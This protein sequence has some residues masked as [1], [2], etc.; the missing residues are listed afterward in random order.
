MRGQRNARSIVVGTG[1]AERTSLKNNVSETGTV[2]LVTVVGGWL[3]VLYC[4]SHRIRIQGM[5]RSL[6]GIPRQSMWDAEH[7][8]DADPNCTDEARIYE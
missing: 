8:V 5:L 2:L 3:A 6:P 7:P 4:K 1:V